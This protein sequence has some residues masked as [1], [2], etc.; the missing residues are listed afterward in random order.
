MTDNSTIEG[1]LIHQGKP[2]SQWEKEFN[3][4]FTRSQLLAMIRGGCDLEKMRLMGLDE[5]DF[6]SLKLSTDDSAISESDYDMN[7]SD[8]RVDFVLYDD[9][10]NEIARNSLFGNDCSNVALDY[11]IQ[12]VDSINNAAKRLPEGMRQHAILY[13]NGEAL[14]PISS[15]RSAQLNQLLAETATEDEDAALSEDEDASTK[16]I[17]EANMDIVTVKDLVARINT[18]SKPT[19]KIMFSVR[20]KSYEVFD[21][22]GKGGTFVIELIPQVLHETEEDNAMNEGRNWRN[23]GYGGTGRS[24]RSFGEF[25]APRGKAISWFAISDIDPKAKG[26]MP[27]WRMGPSNFAFKD[28]LYPERNYKIGTTVLRSKFLKAGDESGVK[29]IAIPSY[30]SAI[31]NNDQ[32]AIEL[33]TSLGIPLDLTFGMD[34]TDDY[35]NTYVIKS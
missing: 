8:S 30:F 33:L 2:L 19:D 21:M 32:A 5:A 7:A 23:G 22:H 4:M 35:S 28:L 11:L 18:Y 20:S 17:N 12:Y 1:S 25:G 10:E 31:Q 6:T 29:Y 13:V 15:I 34:P 14:S 27:D 9:N 26:K 24:Y 3:G 16:A